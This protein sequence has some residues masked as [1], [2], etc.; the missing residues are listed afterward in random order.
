MPRIVH[1]IG[2]AHVDIAWLWQRLEG[3]QE[4][5]ATFSSALER[6]EE[7]E[8]FIFTAAGARY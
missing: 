7:T 4:I 1:M 3:F 6:I 5:R 8:D 2:N